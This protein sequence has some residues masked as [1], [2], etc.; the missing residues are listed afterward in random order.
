MLEWQE[1]VVSRWS[2]VVSQSFAVPAFV[3]SAGFDQR[4]ATNDQ[5]RRL[6]IF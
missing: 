5:R 6:E 1:V 2:L 4:P 3:P